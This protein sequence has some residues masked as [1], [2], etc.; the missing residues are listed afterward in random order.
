MECRSRP[1]ELA[2]LSVPGLAYT[3]QNNLIFLSVDLLSAAVQ[4]VT[5]QLKI[6]CAALLSVLMI[7]KKVTFKQWI[8]LFILVAGVIL[9]QAPQDKQRRNGITQGTLGFLAALGACFASGFGGA[10]RAVGAFSMLFEASEGFEA[11]RGVHGDGLEEL[12]LHLVAQHATGALWGQYSRVGRMAGGQL[13]ADYSRPRAEIELLPPLFLDFGAL[14]PLLGPF[15]RPFLVPSLRQAS[16][17]GSGSWLAQWP[18][19]ACWWRRC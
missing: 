5:Y 16:P 8:S 7:K 11:T 4:Q 9:V 18:L 19:V 10:A 1:L 15:R 13:G 2:K 12:E 6:L 17:F 14:A 3:I